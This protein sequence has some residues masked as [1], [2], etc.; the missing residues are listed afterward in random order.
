MS[1]KHT[2]SFIHWGKWPKATYLCVAK[3]AELLGLSVHLKGKLELN[4]SV[5]GM[6]IRCTCVGP[7]L[8]LKNR[9]LDNHNQNLIFTT[10]ACRSVP[11][12]EQGGFW[13]PP[14]KQL[15][16][17]TNW[18]RLQIFFQRVSIPSIHCQAD[19]VQTET[20]EHHCYPPQE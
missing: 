5:N 13:G 14:R 8:Y 17:L 6:I 11:L 4:I 12:L 1:Q 10:Q 16:M 9:I 19:C 3:V 15:L 18:K 20:I 2:C 7:C